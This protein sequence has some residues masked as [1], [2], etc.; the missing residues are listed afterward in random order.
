MSM[1]HYHI[2]KLYENTATAF[3]IIRHSY[4][5]NYKNF[6]KI[7]DYSMVEWVRSHHSMTESQTM[8]TEDAVRYQ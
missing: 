5:K 8:I 6:C 4:D 2:K 7:I 3:K 1:Y